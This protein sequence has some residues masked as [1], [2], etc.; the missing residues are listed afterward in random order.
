MRPLSNDPTKPGM[1]TVDKR[2]QVSSPALN[3]GNQLDSF[4]PFN[5][6]WKGDVEWFNE[7]L[8]ASRLN[9]EIAPQ[10]DDTMR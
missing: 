6:S 10:L 1:G 8:R 3:K 2:P 7:H 9:P 5:P 4:L